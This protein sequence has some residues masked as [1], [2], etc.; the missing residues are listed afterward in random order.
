MRFTM[1]PSITK[2]AV[3]VVASAAAVLGTAGGALAATSGPASTIGGCV[4]GSSR[5]L[6]NVHSPASNLKGCKKG[7]WQVDWNVQGQRGP[8]GPSGVV[9]TSDTNLVTSPPM[10]VPTG[11]SFTANKTTVGTIH[12]A[13][14]TYLVDVNFMATPNKVTTGQVFP[15]VFVYNGP[16][17]SDFSN[18]LFNV[19]SGGLELA[20][21]SEVTTDPIDSYYSGSAEITV[22]SGGE[23]LDVYAFGYDSDTGP[24]TYALDTLHVTAT[25][26]NPAS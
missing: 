6:E 10:N 24:G 14:G 7:S 17:K 9:S 12:L 23:T 22:P 25:A 15:Q 20:T 4:T 3:V 11:G 26:L 16:Q 19:G 5:T 13:A 18:D 1:K 8:Q 2:K 21:Q